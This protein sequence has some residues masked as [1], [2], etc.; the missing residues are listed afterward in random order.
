MT[1]PIANLRANWIDGN[2]IY[3]S[4]GLHT[5]S[6]NHHANSTIINLSFNGVDIFTLYPNGSL[7]V[8]GDISANNVGDTIDLSGITNSINQLSNTINIL[9]T[10]TNFGQM[11]FANGSDYLQKANNKAIEPSRLWNIGKEVRLANVANAGTITLD[12][13]SGIN[14]NVNITARNQTLAIANVKEQSGYLSIFANA[15]T[16]N[17]AFSS[18][19]RWTDGVPP[20]NSANTTARDLLFYTG[21][22]DGNVFGSLHTNVPR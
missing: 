13:N 11:I 2:T 14:F 17:L 9:A 21:L 12:M 8:L 15:N 16:R 4:L 3:T 6:E 1:K 19:W 10:N 22:S 5:N 18:N 7:I 20:T